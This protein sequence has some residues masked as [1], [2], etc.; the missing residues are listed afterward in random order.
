MKC[1]WVSALLLMFFP[2][3]VMAALTTVTPKALTGP[4][5]NPRIGVASFHQGYGETLGLADYPNTGFE[6]ERFY[7]RDLEPVEGQ[8]N[9]ALVDEAFKYAAAHRPAMNVGL[10]FMVLAEPESGSQIPDWLIKGV[11]GTGRQIKRHL[12]RI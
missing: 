5:T 1:K 3:T 8:Y 4:L 12:S 2:L 6:Y 11:K 9:Y 10:R 7:W